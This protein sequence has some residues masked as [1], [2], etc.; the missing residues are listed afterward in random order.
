MDTLNAQKKSVRVVVTSVHRLFTKQ[1]FEEEA[2][3]RPTTKEVMDALIAGAKDRKPLKKAQANNLVKQTR[4]QMELLKPLGEA[5]N[6]ELQKEQ[7]VFQKRQKTMQA[8]FNKS[9]AVI[10]K[11]HSVEGVL[12]TVER[13]CDRI[14][15]EAITEE[16]AA[17]M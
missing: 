11:N 5:T 10:K 14:S 13:N 7:A 9:K 16:V 6:W 12:E 2:L 15:E 8:G 1:S 17:T 3:T 4:K